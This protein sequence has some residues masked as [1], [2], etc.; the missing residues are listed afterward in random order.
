ML[1]ILALPLAF[2][3][4][5]WL[6]VRN[7]YP[8]ASPELHFGLTG[9]FAI[10]G[11]V[12]AP[13]ALH[14][15]GVPIEPFALATLHAA[16]AA[17]L[18]A[19]TGWRALPW[20]P[21]RLMP[22]PGLLAA[23]CLFA[24]LVLPFTHIAGIDTYKWQDAAD[25]V[26]IERRIA[27]FENPASLFGFT[28]R[29][30]PCAQ[31]LVLASVELLGSTGVDWGFYLVSILFGATALFGAYLLGLRLMGNGKDAAWLAFLYVFSPV[32]MRYNYWATGRGL[33]L[34]LLPMF[35]LALLNPRPAGLW[36]AAALAV[37]LGLGHKAG[38]VA[39][40]LIAPAFLLSL[41][42][43][44][45]TRHSLVATALLLMGVAA[46]ALAS[47]RFAA[48]PLNLLVRPA[49]RLA[50]L[51]PLALAGFLARDEWMSDPRWKAML[52]ASVATVPLLFAREMY[53]AL[54]ALPFAAFAAAAG[55]RWLR[56][57]GPVADPVALQAALVGLVLLQAVAIVIWQ[58]QD[59]PSRAVF[60]AAQFIQRRDPAGPFRIEAPGR[61]RTQIQAYLTGCPRFT[62]KTRP[63]AA[64][65]IVHPP[66]LS[67]HPARDFQNGVTYLRQFVVLDEAET[68][69]Y[70]PV[71]RTYYVTIGPEGFAPPDARRLYTKGNVAV[72]GP[73]D[74]EAR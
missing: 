61:A 44:R 12:A 26:R 4:T 18:V 42:L 29:S 55:V 57:R 59:S 69:W 1:P 9:L 16:T 23:A 58:A 10:V 47:D 14:F 41:A 64:L 13:A 8:R 45:W 39:V 24:I 30:C 63:G 35:I 48:T 5:P 56:E 27:W 2:I 15:A 62:I 21:A 52:I 50:F 46:V 3:V 71:S 40:A 20:R 73:D 54:L 17:L 60:E 49:T 67:G 65:S 34:T 33:L 31:P 7:L 11:N 36:A 70:G 51:A 6:A 22:A 72:Y 38:L 74:A 25:N 68:D 53:G 37:L 19:L 32:F 28:P 66:P 43:K